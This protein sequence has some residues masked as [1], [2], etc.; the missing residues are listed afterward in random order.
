MTWI[1]TFMK[2]QKDNSYKRA[3][4][5]LSFCRVYRLSFIWF[6]SQ[7]RNTCGCVLKFSHR[8]KNVML[9]LQIVMQLFFIII[10]EVLTLWHVN[11]NVCCRL[12][13]LRSKMAEPRQNSNRNDFMP[14]VKYKHSSFTIK[15]SHSI[16]RAEII[17]F[18]TLLPPPEKFL[19]EPWVRVVSFNMYDILF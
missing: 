19:E 12:V 3:R 5:N 7:I 8:R 4:D 18:C 1:H 13:D 9:V 2:Q 16:W 10:V 6:S 11:I 14:V 17:F 15:K